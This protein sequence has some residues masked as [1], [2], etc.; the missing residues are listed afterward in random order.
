V[1]RALLR[2][3]RVEIGGPRSSP[4]TVRTAAVEVTDASGE[5]GSGSRAIEVVPVNDPPVWTV[6]GLSLS[7][8]EEETKQ[9]VGLLAA[10]DPEGVGVLYEVVCVGEKV[11]TPPSIAL[12]LAAS[13]MTALN[14]TS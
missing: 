9:F 2:G 4:D 12:T 14:I 1:Y 6:G 11:Y 7:M 13:L 3:C 8:V 5:T 10:E